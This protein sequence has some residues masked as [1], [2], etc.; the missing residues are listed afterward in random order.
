VLFEDDFGSWKKC[1]ESSIS[2]LYIS[3]KR[4]TSDYAV[5]RFAAELIDQRTR[6]YRTPPPDSQASSDSK[7]APADD[8]SSFQPYGRALFDI[9]RANRHPVASCNAISILNAAGVGFQARDF[10]GLDL[11]GDIF[12]LNPSSAS[13][14]PE[15]E[16]KATSSSSS[17]L[18][19]LADLSGA[20]LS[21]C[22]LLGANLR[23]VRLENACLDYADIRGA[24]MEQTIFGQSSMFLGHTA[25]VISITLSLDGRSLFSTSVD[26]TICQWSVD[27]GTS[28]R[29]FEGHTNNVIPCLISR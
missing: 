25:E 5:L 14:I 6:S 16:Q 24:A 26:K 11:S 10:T 22:K 27:S 17:A 8:L 7:S 9:L 12:P 21:G 18:V 4:V 15:T 19:P 1:L 20:N 28:I 2:S 13:T 3:R 23:G 29:V